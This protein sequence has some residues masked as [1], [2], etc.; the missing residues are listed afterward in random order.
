MK[1]RIIDLSVSLQN[2]IPSDPPPFLPS[3]DYA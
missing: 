2:G 3:I 1:Q